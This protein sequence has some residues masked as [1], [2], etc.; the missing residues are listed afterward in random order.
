MKI[1]DVRELIKLEKPELS[2]QA[3]LLRKSH[4]VEDFEKLSRRR[5]PTPV[6]NYVSGG[7]DDEVTLAENTAAF[8]KWRFQPRSLI[9]VSGTSLKTD[10]LGKSIEAPFGFS[11]TGFTR[12]MSPL[13]EPAV[14]AAAGKGGIPYTL[15]TMGSTSIEDLAK[16]PG[17][18]T[19]DR[20]FQLYVWKNRDLADALVLR[21]QQNGY[22]V[23]EIAIDTVVSGFRVRDVRGGLT[24]PPQFTPATIMKFGVRP[25]Y[26]VR[27]LASPKIEFANAT[28]VSGYSIDSITK[29]FDPTLQWDTIERIRGMWKGPMLIKG[30][31]SPE[32]AV[33]AKS[34]GIDGVHLSNHGG[35]QLDRSVPPADLIAPVRAATG[36]D[37]TIV[38]DS[39]IRHGNDIATSIALGADAAFM[40]RPYLWALTALGQPGVERL[41]E[42]LKEQTL[43]AMQLMGVQSIAD[44]RARGPQVLIADDEVEARAKA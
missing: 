41:I 9:D 39:G 22:R 27:M 15:S 34:I 37:F 40:G 35:R 6:F 21:A 24:I 3:R 32:D 18:D 10:V 43:R 11:P 1:N 7:A 5:L 19:T 29:Q 28:G 16:A 23:L 13:G 2:R 30:P 12:M 33:Y 25:G 20:W 38:V 26:W 31:I 42:L 4:T 14:M 8:R 36:D 44:L 17:A